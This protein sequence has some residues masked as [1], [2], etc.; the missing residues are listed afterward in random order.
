MHVSRC[1]GCPLA[2][3]CSWSQFLTQDCVHVWYC[4]SLICHLWELQQL[5]LERVFLRA[6]WTSSRLNTAW[7]KAGAGFRTQMEKLKRNRRSAAMSLW[8]R[9]LNWN[10]VLS[11]KA[12]ECAFIVSNLYMYILVLWVQRYSATQFSLLSKCGFWGRPNIVFLRTAL[13]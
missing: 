6:F 11:H 13:L 10:E 3:S 12:Y 4:N 2:S 8:G 1:I 7:F 9:W 5:K